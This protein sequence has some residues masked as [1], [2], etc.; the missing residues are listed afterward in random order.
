M[1]SPLTKRVRT[2]NKRTRAELMSVNEC[3][4]VGVKGAKGRRCHLNENNCHSR[5]GT[6]VGSM[7]WVSFISNNNLQPSLKFGKRTKLLS[8]E[9]IYLVFVSNVWRPKPCWR[10]MARVQSPF[11]TEEEAITILVPGRSGPI[12][13]ISEERKRERNEI[14]TNGVDWRIWYVVQIVDLNVIITFLLTSIFR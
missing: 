1:G 10:S 11:E 4:L 6:C 5:V 3:F 13:P 2:C 9:M 8:L 12:R 14:S 7:L